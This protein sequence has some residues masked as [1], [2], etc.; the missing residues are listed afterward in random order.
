[1]LTLD[2]TTNILK[3]AYQPGPT[4]ATRTH[5]SRKA[6]SLVIG[7]SSV[8]LKISFFVVAD[9][10]NRLLLDEKSDFQNGDGHWPMFGP[11]GGNFRMTNL[12]ETDHLTL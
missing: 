10:S 12:N 3:T 8:L 1:M 11:C 7:K 6:F 5:D 2:S 4:R 9:C